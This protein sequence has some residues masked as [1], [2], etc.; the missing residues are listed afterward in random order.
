MARAYDD[1]YADPYGGPTQPMKPDDGQSYWWNGYEWV[2][3]PPPTGGPEGTYSAPLAPGVT[4]GPAQTLTNPEPTP[5]PAP[6]PAPAPAPTVQQQST[7]LSSLASAPPPNNENFE[8]PQF[9]APQFT[10][11]QPFSYPEFS[12]GGYDAP[13]PFQYENFSAPTMDQAA[14]DPGYEFARTE[15]LRA[16]TNRAS[17]TGSARTGGTMKDLITW[18]NK[19]A[20]QNYGNVYNRNLQTYGTNRNNA[21]ESWGANELA[22]A[23]AYDR[24]RGNA[25]GNYETNRNNAASDY[26]TNYGVS[27]DVFDRSYTGALDEFRPKQDAAQR[28]FDDLYRRW[29]AEL[30]AT[31]GTAN[32]G[33]A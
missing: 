3:A 25:F 6:A 17:A 29:K 23:Q 20:D 2:W 33:A 27:R 9:T 4:Y 15:G 24:D 16:L 5:G 31:M 22:R 10:A 13:D 26:M 12:Y 21:F 1:E 18:G 32:M 30:D 14:Q 8:W 11:P 28:T 19:F 7:S